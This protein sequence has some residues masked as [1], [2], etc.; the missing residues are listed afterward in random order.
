[1]PPPSPRI[2]PRKVKRARRRLPVVSECDSCE[3]YVCRQEELHR[4]DELFAAM[5]D[6]P[7]PEC[8]DRVPDFW[9]RMNNQ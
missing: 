6:K 7:Q 5:N 9:E 8:A 2:L 4:R 1:M 3:V